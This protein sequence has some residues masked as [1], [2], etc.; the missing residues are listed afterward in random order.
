MSFAERNGG[1]SPMFMA[2]V[3]FT[4]VSPMISWWLTG[5]LGVVVLSWPRKPDGARSR[6]Y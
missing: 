2:V 3:A 5:V 6:K 4:F 1:W